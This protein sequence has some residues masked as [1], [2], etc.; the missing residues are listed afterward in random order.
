MNVRDLHEKL[1]T[2][3]SC[4][5][6]VPRAYMEFRVPLPDQQLHRARFVYQAVGVMMRGQSE[7][8]EPILCAWLWQRLVAAFPKEEMEDRD[9]LLIF[10]RWPQIVEFVDGEGY[11]AT[12]LTTRLVIPGDDLKRIFGDAVI[13]EGEM[14]CRL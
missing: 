12:K 6:G 9:V 11:A 10:R 1:R 13:N 7:D 3:F 5:D 2:D 8:I 14:L 4:I